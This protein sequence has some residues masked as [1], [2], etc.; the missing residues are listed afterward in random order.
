M[1]A[2]LEMTVIIHVKGDDHPDQGAAAET[3]IRYTVRDG[4]QEKI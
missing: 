2:P 1:E 4:T 3:G